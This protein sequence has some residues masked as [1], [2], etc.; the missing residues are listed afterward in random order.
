M[1]FHCTARSVKTKGQPSPMVELPPDVWGSI[2]SR[3]STRDWAKLSRAHPAL[4]KAQPRSIEIDQD[5][6]THLCDDDD[7]DAPAEDKLESTASALIWITRHWQRANSIDLDLSL[8]LEEPYEELVSACKDGGGLQQSQAVKRFDGFI[9]AGPDY[10]SDLEEDEEMIVNPWNDMEE[11]AEKGKDLEEVVCWLLGYLP[12]LE[13][14][15]KIT[16]MAPHTSRCS[17]C[18][19]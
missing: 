5:R 16:H 18:N 15:F 14:I 1:H 12:A 8:N 11:R 10:C 2:A 7:N 6:P 9:R 4:A 19:V 13:V 17:A 3:F